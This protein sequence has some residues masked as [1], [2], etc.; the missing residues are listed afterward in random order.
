MELSTFVEN[1]HFVN[2]WAAL[3]APM[4]LMVLDFA[5]GYLGACI[6]RERDSRKMREGGGHKAAE[7]ACIFA[8][9]I[10][11]GSLQFD[12]KF[13]YIVSAYIMLM[14]L[15]S[16]AENVRKMLGKKTPSIIDHAIDQIHEDLY[17]DSVMSI[18]HSA[19]DNYHNAEDTGREPA[20]H[21]KQ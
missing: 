7:L 11:D 15:V 17:D 4:L 14:E 1:I 2:F 6:R 18:E 21:N 12:V 9:L 20:E 10:V 16:I 19:Y 13:V 8:A 5:T 3:W